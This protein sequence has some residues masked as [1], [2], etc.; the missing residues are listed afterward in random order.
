MDIDLVARERA[1]AGTAAEHDRR[2]GM[3][4]LVEFF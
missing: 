4:G 1:R 2:Q 3:P